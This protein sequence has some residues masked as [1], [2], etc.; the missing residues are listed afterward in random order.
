MRLFRYFLVGGTAAVID[1]GVFGVLVKVFGLPW[2]PV[3]VCSFV[4]ATAV[5]YFLSVRFVFKSGV[6]FTPNTELLLVFV[7]SILGLA[8]NQAVLWLLISRA[9]WDPLFAKVTATGSV[10]FWN[11]WARRNLVFKAV[12]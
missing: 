12:D 3:A 10:F 8:V 9:L 4:L 11:Y 2:F 6:R 5:N 1:I 7:I